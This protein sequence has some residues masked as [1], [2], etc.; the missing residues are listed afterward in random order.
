MMAKVYTAGKLKEASGKGRRTLSNPRT[1]NLTHAQVADPLI[2]GTVA[3]ERTAPTAL[4]KR[5]RNRESP[6]LLTW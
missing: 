1:A 2:R 6:I 3:Q 4:R 5:R